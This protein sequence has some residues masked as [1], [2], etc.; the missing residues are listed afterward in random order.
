M[1]NS[2]V[3]FNGGEAGYNTYRIPALLRAPGGDLLLF[4]EGRKHDRHD[5]GQIDILMKRSQNGGDT[6]GAQE[7]VVSEPEM[8]CGNPCPVV[9][10]ATGH[11]LLPFCKNRSDGGQN[12]IAQ[13]KAPRTVWLTRSTDEGRSWREP[14]EITDQVKKNSWTWYATGPGHGIQLSNGRL[15]VP[16]DHNVGVYHQRGKD[17]YGSHVIYSDDHGETWH[18]GAILSLPGNECG[19]AEVDDDTL[20][21]NARTRAEHGVRSYGFSY[22]GGLSFMEEGFHSEL[23]EPQL[24]AGG[25]QGSLL[26][27]RDP[28][29]EADLLLFCNPA[30]S[31]EERKRLAIHVSEDG[32]HSWSEARVIQPGPAGYSDM[33]E[34]EDGAIV[35]VHEAG[36]EAYHER[37]EVSRFSVEWLVE[38]IKQ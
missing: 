36:N 14:E 7:V 31:S 6:W 26:K 23:V 24:Y 18:I 28:E 1:D 8:T 34:S 15:V 2:Q 32:G 37:L 4:C 38:G 12:L 21:L 27:V 25:C 29:S 30:T 5:T 19:V 22:D 9:D 17:P 10:R 13:G 35:C 3:I 16:C 20:Y 11:I 33:V